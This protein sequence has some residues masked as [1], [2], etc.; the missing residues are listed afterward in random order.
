VATLPEKSHWLNTLT[1]ESE[2]FTNKK[3][4][5]KKELSKQYTAVDEQSENLVEVIFIWVLR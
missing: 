3:L 2:R 5:S 4:K 1:D